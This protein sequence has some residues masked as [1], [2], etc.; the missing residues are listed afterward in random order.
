M[1]EREV[2][3]RE[4]QVQGEKRR[5]GERFSSFKPQSSQTDAASGSIHLQ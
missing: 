3:Y 5:V 1:R 4:E 2:K